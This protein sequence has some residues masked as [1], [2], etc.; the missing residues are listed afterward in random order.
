MA[1][2]VVQA[3]ITLDG[4]VQSPSHVDDD[5]EGGF[6]RGGWQAD[7]GD[8]GVDMIPEWESRTEAL[9]LG[10]KTYEPW[11]EYWGSAD[12][13]A[14][15]LRGEL[16]RRYNRVPKFV[17]SRT[18]T[19]VG[20]ANSHLLGADVPGSVAAL[21]RDVAAGEI[22]VWGS[23]QLIA[24]LAQHDLVDEY[25]LICYPVV[26]GAGKRLFAEGFAQTRLAVVES[27]ALASGVLVTRYRRAQQ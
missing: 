9:L 22:R 7:F 10:R 21:K 23:T 26:V 4:V 27:I 15:G 13:G 25:R 20:W 11:A 2:I 19:E 12:Q 3:F 17:A 6:D 18:L 14:P 24:T 16:A 8:D 5:R 1:E